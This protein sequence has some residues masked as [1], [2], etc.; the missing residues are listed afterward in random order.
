MRAEYF[1]ERRCVASTL[2]MRRTRRVAAA[3]P[4]ENAFRP[5]GPAVARVSSGK[6]P[7][8]FQRL[9]PP[10]ELVRNSYPGATIRAGGGNNLAPKLLHL[11]PRLR[12]GAEDGWRR[13]G[14]RRSMKR[15]QRGR[16]LRNLHRRSIRPLD[17]CRMSVAPRRRTHRLVARPAMQRARSANSFPFFTGACEKESSGGVVLVI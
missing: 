15:V 7:P 3:R 16:I 13:L 1:A 8:V 17:T 2:A 10:R 9:E 12:F 4:A 14:G 11:R 6:S 5:P